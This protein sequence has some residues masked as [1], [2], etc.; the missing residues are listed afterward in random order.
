MQ[1]WTIAD[2]EKMDIPPIQEMT[3]ENKWIVLWLKNG[4]RIKFLNW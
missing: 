4:M 1:H 3:Y 2:F